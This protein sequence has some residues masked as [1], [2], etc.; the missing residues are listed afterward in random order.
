MLLYSSKYHD[1]QTV[2]NLSGRYNLEKGIAERLGKDFLEMIKK[3]S[4]IDVKNRAGNDS[5]SL[6]CLCI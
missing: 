3:D 4:F 6:S 2:I 1:V 5:I